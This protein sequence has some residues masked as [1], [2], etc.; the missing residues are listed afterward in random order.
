MNK[1]AVFGSPIAHSK[2]PQIHNYLFEQLGINSYYT[3]IISDNSIHA[4]D[5]AKKLNLSG[6]NATMPLKKALFAEINSV[7]EISKKAEAV[8]TVLIDNPLRGFNTDIYGIINSLKGIDLGSK[9]IAV[10]GAGAAAET[11]LIALAESNSKNIGLYNRTEN[12]KQKLLEKYSDLSSIS[13]N[14]FSDFDIIISTIPDLD[15]TINEIKDEQ[16]ILNADYIYQSKFSNCKNY[17]SGLH[18]LINQALPAFELFSNQKLTKDFS[19]DIRSMLEKSHNTNTIYLIGFMGSGKSKLGLELSKK[20][21]T[22]LIDLDLFIESK[23]SMKIS[24]IFEKY[25]E[26]YFRNLELR[27][28]KELDG[29]KGIIA[30]GGGIITNQYSCQII[31]NNGFRIYIYSKSTDCFE[32]TKQDNSRPLRKD[33]DGFEKLYNS[34]IDKYFANSDLIVDNSSDFDKTINDIEKEIKIIYEK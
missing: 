32:R 22:E 6:F 4:I 27:Y 7:D 31:K 8:N 34:R 26:E 33:F 1:Y 19:V 3:R 5:L 24:Y 16:I 13:T 23:E 14:D 2:S 9:R 29:F 10:L 21:D 17:I 15:S 18:W 30:C 11:A 12:N 28:L 25:G 20:L